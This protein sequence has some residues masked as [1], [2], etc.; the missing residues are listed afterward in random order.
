MH[1]NA[2]LLLE[3]IYSIEYQSLTSPIS[4]PCQL[5]VLFRFYM[6]GRVAQHRIREIV[7]PLQRD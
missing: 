6:Q 2:T 5:F 1:H 3:N 4:K 7:D